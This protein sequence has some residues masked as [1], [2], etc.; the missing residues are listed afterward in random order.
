MCSSRVGWRTLKTLREVPAFRNLSARRLAKIDA[1]VD[2]VS[3][4][5]G[6]VLVREGQF[7]GDALIVVSGLAEVTRRGR[8]VG[9][10]GPGAFIAD[11]GLEELAPRTA[12]ITARTP[13]RLL[14][15]GPAALSTLLEDSAVT[16]VIL[17]ELVGRLRA[18]DREV[19]AA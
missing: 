13:I 15:V 5:A 2:E 8:H 14:A 9:A 1:L 19:V 18:A 12:T 11:I 7:R 3:V 17:Q 16:R 4:P 6:H 10:I